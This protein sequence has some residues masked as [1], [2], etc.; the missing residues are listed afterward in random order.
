MRAIEINDISKV[1]ECKQWIESHEK[2]LLFF[3]SGDCPP[4]VVMKEKMDRLLNSLAW[5]SEYTLFRIH[6]ESAME[7]IKI[8]QVKSVPTIFFIENGKRVGN[9]IGTLKDITITRRLKKF[10]GVSNG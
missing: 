2:V 5:K 4:C 10:L 9:I 7:L 1:E 6:A 8:Y 3:V